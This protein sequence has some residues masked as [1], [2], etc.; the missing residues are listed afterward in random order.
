MK[1]YTEEQVRKAM[2]DARYPSVLKASYDE[3]L[4]SLIPIE[5][6]SD[7]EIEKTSMQ[8]Y[9]NKGSDMY[10]TVGAKWMKDKILNQNNM[11]SSGDIVGYTPKTK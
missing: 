2:Q 3:I 9:D 1:L 10:F 11:Y 6:P 5:L 4:E 7:E 8:F